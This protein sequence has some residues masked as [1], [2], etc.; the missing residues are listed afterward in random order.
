M[1]PVRLEPAA[2]WSRAKLS[3]TEPLRSQCVCV[4][5][6]VCVLVVGV[7]H[8]K[9]SIMTPLSATV[10]RV[11]SAPSVGQGGGSGFNA[12]YSHNECWYMRALYNNGNEHRRLIKMSH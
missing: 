11:S 3:T 1:T 2:P 12:F 10:P 5:V 9:T 4:C 8:L 6:C 7:N